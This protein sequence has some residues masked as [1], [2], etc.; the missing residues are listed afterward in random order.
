MDDRVSGARM[1]LG[2]TL[3]SE[4]LARELVL[5]G[6]LVPVLTDAIG[7]VTNV[8]LVWPPTEF[9][10]PK[11]RAFIDLTLEIVAGM[12]KARDASYAKALGS[13]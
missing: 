11:V 3:A 4:R 7:S 12:M 5:D 13:A 9:M 2:L 8:H 6:H 10:D 1:G